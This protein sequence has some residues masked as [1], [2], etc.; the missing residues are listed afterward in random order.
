MNKRNL[1]FLVWVMLLTLGGSVFA[2]PILSHQRLSVSIS[3]T[4]FPNPWDDYNS[5]VRTV[6]NRIQKDLFFYEPIG[7]WE[8]INGD[9]GFLLQLG[10]ELHPHWQFGLNFSR[11]QTGARFYFYPDPAQITD[12]FQL[13]GSYAFDQDINFSAT[14]F[15]L[16]IG[17]QR[18]V[19]QKFDGFAR[20]GA[21]RYSGNFELSYLYDNATKTALTTE[22]AFEQFT[23]KLTQSSIGYHANIGIAYRIGKS[24]QIRLSGQYRNLSFD[25]LRGD[26]TYTVFGRSLDAEFRLMHAK[27]Y[28][29]VGHVL[30]GDELWDFL[31]SQN[32]G[33]REISNLSFRT[34]YFYE[35]IWE[36][37]TV[38][39]SAFGIQLGLSWEF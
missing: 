23:G 28:F 34:D 20:I 9:A 25:D 30:E 14:G 17:Y 1:V 13:S 8:E 11:Y 2:Q 6:T 35:N 21:A 31:Y 38:D 10:Y 16:G 19:W 7:E 37:A 24:L 29:G 39:L 18:P 22:N 26:G 27:N 32:W 36:P 33:N 15:G 4:Y 5:A 3:G 12:E